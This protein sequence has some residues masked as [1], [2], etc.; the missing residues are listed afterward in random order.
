MPTDK[1]KENIQK[2]AQSAGIPTD[3]T[4]KE[5]IPQPIAGNWLHRL[6]G[7]RVNVNVGGVP[8]IGQ[9][10]RYNMLLFIIIILVIIISTNNKK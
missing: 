7:N 10:P 5:N 3:L 8:V 4:T 2:F 6:L 9:P 1:I